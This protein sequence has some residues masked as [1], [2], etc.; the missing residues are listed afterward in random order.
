MF[1][2]SNDISQ[3]VGDAATPDVFIFKHSATCPVSA[4]ARQQVEAWMKKSGHDVYLVVVQSARPLSN[5]IAE[6]MGI[7]HE[8]PQF[9]A[10][11]AGT[12]AAL[13]HNEITPENLDALTGRG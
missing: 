3:I 13:S 5:A 6:K 12:V 2:Q 1:K 11:K 10:V 8:S 4:W 7:R 9:I